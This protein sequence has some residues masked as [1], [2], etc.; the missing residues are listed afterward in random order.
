MFSQKNINS[1]SAT[2]STE[3]NLLPPKNNSNLYDYESSNGL[4]KLMAAYSI[5]SKNC[6]TACIT[7]LELK[8]KNIEHIGYENNSKLDSCLNRCLVQ[9][10]KSHFPEDDNITDFIYSTAFTY[11]HRNQF[12]L[13]AFNVSNKMNNYKEDNC[14]IDTIKNVSNN[15]NNYF[16]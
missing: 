6:N 4:N 1:N 7:A 14:I 12:H 16:L 8:D 9:R 11:S 5:I 13:N 3:Y 15:A 2:M 10:M